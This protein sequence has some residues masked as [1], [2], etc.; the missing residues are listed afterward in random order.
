MT[1]G[2]QANA[3]HAMGADLTYECL[4]GNTYKVRFSFY[5][6][7]I[8]IPAPANVYI[9]VRSAS[10]NQNL[11]VT[12]NPIPGTG[13]QVTYLCPTATSTCNGGTFTGIQEWVY[14]GI[15]TLP[16]QCTDWQFSYSL[17]CRNAAI[18]TITNPGSNTFYIYA[19]LNNVASTCNSSPVFSNK[20][21]P[22]ACLGQQLCFNH[23]AVDADGDSLVYSL[24][25]PKQTATTN[26]SYIGPYSATTPL[27]S[28]PAI[29][30]NTATGDIC[31]TPQQLQVTVMAVLVQEYRNG[32]LIGSVVRDI[33]VTVLNCNNSLP[34]LTGINGTN[35]FD[36]TVCANDPLCFNVFSNDPDAGQQ[37]S[38]FYNNAIPAAT[39]NTAGTPHPT[40][41]FCWTPSQADIS[42][43]P[44]CFTLRVGDD[45]CPYIGS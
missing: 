26:V 25:N 29:Q 13:Q 18:T 9:S 20:P 32:V 14:E 6:D 11:G 30:F 40:G 33:Q 23:G 39:F 1:S 3:S 35:D 37:L 43:N 2:Y 19:N 17:C 31:F 10:C 27:N 42:S 36:I 28:S 41:T 7:C 8:G 16:M 24:V 21:V 22:F 34:T 12:A 38:V 5:R 15:I 4:G 44:Y 45:A